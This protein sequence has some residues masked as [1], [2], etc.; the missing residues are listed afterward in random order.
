MVI[1]NDM[2][3]FFMCLFA[4]CASPLIKYL[5]FFFFF[6]LFAISLATPAGGSQARGRIGDVAACQQRRI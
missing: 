6:G 3:H 1:A 5:F 4:M 2:E